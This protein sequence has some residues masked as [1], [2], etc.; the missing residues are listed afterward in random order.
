MNSK[1]KQYWSVH[2]GTHY[3]AILLPMSMYYMLCSYKFHL[4]LNKHQHIESLWVCL[5]QSVCSQARIATFLHLN[6][7]KIKSFIALKVHIP[8]I[9]CSSPQTLKMLFF[10][11]LCTHIVKTDTNATVQRIMIPMARKIA[12][13]CQNPLAI[14]LKFSA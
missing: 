8:A 12:V 3:P 10:I 6:H 9:P 14:S 13:A 2:F 1:Q 4:C 5:M 7:P 11:I